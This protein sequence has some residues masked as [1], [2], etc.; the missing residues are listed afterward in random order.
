MWQMHFYH[1]YMSSVH[2]QTP[3]ARRRQ[4]LQREGRYIDFRY[5]S[6]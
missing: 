5:V 1:S 3:E 2:L 6:F 4:R